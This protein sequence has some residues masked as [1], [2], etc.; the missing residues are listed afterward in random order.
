MKI[1]FISDTHGKHRKASIPD[2]DLLI[3]GGDVTNGREGQMLDF[4]N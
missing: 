3:H 2:G 1:V 4:L